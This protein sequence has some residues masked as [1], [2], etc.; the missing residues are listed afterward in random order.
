MNLIAEFS[1]SS[2]ISEVRYEKSPVLD[3]G[4]MK[5]TFLNGKSYTYFYVPTDE[6]IAFI[7]ADSLGGYFNQNIRDRYEYAKS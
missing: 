7:A 1:T 2:L 5:V 4:W 3:E 6:V